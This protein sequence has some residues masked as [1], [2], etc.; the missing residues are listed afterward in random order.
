[1]ARKI[2]SFKYIVTVLLTVGILI[3][4]GLNVQQKRR[5]IPPDDGASWVQGPRGIEARLIL[6]DGP[7][8]KRESFV[9]IY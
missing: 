8:V 7:A 2:F 6:A 1:M 4:G 9:A 3:L 5:Y